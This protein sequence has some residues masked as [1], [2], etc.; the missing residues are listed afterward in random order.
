MFISR[1]IYDSLQRERSSY[2]DRLI[3]ALADTKAGEMRISELETKLAAAET[4]IAELEAKLAMAEHDDEIAEEHQDPIRSH[5]GIRAVVAKA[6][7][8]ARQQANHAQAAAGNA[9]ARKTS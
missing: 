3:T 8:W 1:E 4:K 2:A 7:D 5:L 9:P 6:N